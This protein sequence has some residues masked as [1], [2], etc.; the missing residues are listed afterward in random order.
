M[1]GWQFWIDR[2]GTFTDIVARDPM[3]RLSML[4]LLSENP[5]QYADA[6]LAGIRRCLGLGPSDT[7]APESL[8]SVKMGTTV[9]TNALLER[10]G[11][12]TALVVTRGFADVLRIGQQN[13]PDLFAH[14]ITLPEMLY[15]QVV[16]IDER[17]GAGGEILRPLDLDAAERDLCQ[18]FDTGL[19]AV[20]IVLMHGY[21]FPK[22]E[23]LLGQLASKIGFSQISLSHEASPLMKIIGRGDTTVVDA[24]LSPILRRYV[25][26]VAAQLGGARLLFMQSSGGLTDARR[27]HGKD[28]ILS[29]PAGGVVG[30]VATS[31]QAGFDRLIGFDMGGTSTD[32][33]HYDG[34]FE[35]SFDTMVA[36]VRLR[37]PIMD[38]HTVAAGGGSILSFESGRFRAGPHSAGANPGPACYRRGGPLTVTDCNVMLGRVQPAYFPAVFGPD[39][40]QPL[41][42]QATRAGFAALAKRADRSPEQVAQG[43]LSIAVANMANAIKH[44]SV[45][46][47]HDVSRHALACFGGAG[48]Q[49]ACLV[50]DCLAMDT[51]ILHPLAGVLSAYG[52]GL[53]DLRVLKERAIETV[54]SADTMPLINRAMADIEAIARCELE[55]QGIE[56]LDMSASRRLKVKYQGA[57]TA[58]E[59]A[60][61]VEGEIAES[62]AAAH[63]ARFGF[64][65]PDKALVVESAAIEVAGGGEAA[66]L[67]PLETASHPAQPLGQTDMYCDDAWT[68]VPVFARDTLAAG[69]RIIGPAMIVEPTTT[70]I[71]EPGWQAEMIAQ[72]HLLLHRITA[73]KPGIAVG[74]S[75]DPVLLEIFNNLFMSV[76]EQMGAVLAN[77]AHS[78]NIKERLD[79]SCAV[80]DAHGGLIANA[81]HI[82]VHLGS[83]GESVRT[84]LTARAKTMRPGQSFVLNSPYNGGT[85]LPDVTVITPVFIGGRALFFVASRGHHADIGGITPGSMPPGSTSIDQEGV[86][87]DDFVLVEDGRFRL[88]EI[89]DLLQSGPHP[90]R[91]VAQNI[92]DLQ[93]QLAANEKGAAELS[94]LCQQYGEATVI[95][96]M[97]HVQDNAEEAVRQAIAGLNDASFA[98]EMDDGA[99]IRVAITIDRI[100]RSARIDFTGTSAQRSGNANAPKSITRAAVLYVFRCIV[101]D[102]IPLNEGCLKPLEIIIPEGSM[103]APQ[104][105]AAVVAGNVETSQAVVDCLMAALSVMAASQGTMNNL[106]F[107]DDSRQYY[108]TICGGAGAGPGFAG[109]SAVQTHMTNSRLT[110]PEVLEWRFPV[111]VDGFTIR[112]H[113]GGTGQWSGG[114]GVIRR[115][116]FQEP[117]TA[118]ILSNR[119]RIQPFGLNGGGDAKPGA[120][121]VE[122]ADGRIETL[123]G[124]AQIQVQPGDVL[125]IET[126]GGGGFG[127]KP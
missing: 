62:F 105:P 93:A 116:K 21:R 27:F 54:L 53:A 52:M 4:K 115:L 124:T 78:V 32:V 60:F 79:F 117:M 16:E 45:A 42:A 107:G 7:I 39:G 2:G 23:Q 18:A 40:D 113:S 65:M 41:D 89:Q 56:R 37:A 83:M 59:V 47:G 97:G 43:F 127:P 34:A 118:A 5:E 100:A 69:H 121:R 120:N 67:A 102:C 17:L 28:A 66:A 49:H 46:R 36:G 24:Y 55:R 87:I 50:A 125:V 85:H 112:R 8:G 103:L 75:A 114:D 101:N 51:V 68:R 9:A 111:L 104:A 48:G 33:W 86:L 95:A 12:P 44:V 119:R 15:T 90:A 99:E 61:A 98:V 31:A 26:Q 76:A 35:R 108:E 82:P 20:A 109:A 70:T 91:N 64:V 1:D 71:V 81:P 72:G 92:A 10:R 13:R 57:D 22:H 63:R 84:I 88:A 106:T 3:G 74:T 11:E 123:P 6:A 96:Y 77:T 14:A 94:R 110:D 19:R 29:G 126:P 122:R 25:D 80:F 30:G 38:I 73:R 58:L